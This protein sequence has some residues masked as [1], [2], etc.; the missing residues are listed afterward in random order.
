MP[1]LI[2]KGIKEGKFPIKT[3]TI[4]IGRDMSNILRLEDTKIS[5]K[6]CRIDREENRFSIQ[7]LESS[8]G[9]YVN[10]TLIKE[11]KELANGD[12]VEVGDTLIIFTLKEA[13]EITSLS[14]FLPKS[15]KELV[16]DFDQPKK[17]GGARKPDKRT[18]ESGKPPPPAG[19]GRD[20]GDTETPLIKS[21]AS[22]ERELSSPTQESLLRDQRSLKT[23]YQINRVIS[24]VFDL[25]EVLNKIIDIALRVLRAERGFIMLRN[26]QTGEL[27]PQAVRNRDAQEITI[28]KTIVNKVFE[29]GKSVLTD[30]AMSDE[31]FSGGKSIVDYH[32]RSCL[33]VPLKSKDK[34]L[35]IMHIDNKLSARSFTEEDLELLSAIGAEAGVL[36]ENAKL[37]TANLKAER[38]SA[39]GQTIAGLSHYVKN[40]L[41]GVEGGNT[42]V[43]MGLN[44]GNQELLKK[45]WKVVRSSNERISQLV[46]NMLD[47]SRERKPVREKTNINEIVNDVVSLMEERCKQKSISIEAK[48]DKSNPEIEIDPIGI[49]R[50][51]LNIVTNAIDA[52]EKEKG[53]IVI[54]TVGAESPIQ[55]SISDN[56]SGIPQ[57]DIPKIFDI[58]HSSKGAGGTG[59]GLAVTKKII[60]EH[61]GEIKVESK[62][63]QGT[64]FTII[65]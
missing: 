50:A 5:R 49:H 22:M 41:T 23:L 30:D 62:K 25:K 59:L 37:Y 24:S 44:H 4:T 29:S 2:I 36:V 15:E 11:R 54:T 55:I 3:D 65:L 13:D 18:P 14:E 8:N 9:T 58:F 28:S 40:I 52:V 20:E 21:L 35:G 47:F 53:K 57:E 12:S 63:G 19:K 1:T 6:H 16:P 38:L 61:K 42:L 17:A 10:E 32:I 39:I 33:C 64:T 46:L 56:G 43:D 45:G 60:D 26:E 7:D 34:T 51:V 48:L 31:R 27:T